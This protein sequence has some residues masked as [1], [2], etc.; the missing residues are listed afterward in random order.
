MREIHLHL[1]F[2]VRSARSFA[3]FFPYVIVLSKRNQRIAFTNKPQI[4]P[5]RTRCGS[6]NPAVSQLFATGND[7][8]PR[9]AVNKRVFVQRAHRRSVAC[10]IPH[11]ERKSFSALGKLNCKAL[12][13]RIVTP[14]E[15]RIAHRHRRFEHDVRRFHGRYRCDFGITYPFLRIQ[16]R[17]FIHHDRFRESV[18]IDI[19]VATFCKILNKLQFRRCGS[20]LNNNLFLRISLDRKSIRRAKKI[21]KLGNALCIRRHL[22]RFAETVGKTNFRVD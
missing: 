15:S 16:R 10:V 21:F 4:Q 18:D 12:I 17:G 7:I 19:I 13:L 8:R 14:S 2:V 5:V 1:Q 9:P 11:P 3:E 22:N 6:I 20:F